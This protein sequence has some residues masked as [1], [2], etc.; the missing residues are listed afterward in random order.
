VAKQAKEPESLQEAIVYFSKP[1][2]C[3]SYMIARRWPNGV[4]CPTC[5]SEKVGFIPTRLLWECKA[6]HAKRQFSAKIGTVMEDSAIGLDKWLCAFW[7]V[8]NCK[9]GVSSYEIH[10][11]IRVTQKSAWFML[12][13]IRL[14][15]H[16][17]PG[18]KAGGEVEADETFVG[19]KVANMHKGRRV[20]IQAARSAIRDLEAGGKTGK[21][22][23][24]GILDRQTRQIRARVIPNVRREVLQ[25][26]ILKHVEHGSSVYTDDAGGYRYLPVDKFVHAVVDHEKEYV[27]GRVHTN[28]LENFWS[29]LKRS[30]KGTYVAVEPFHLDRY[31]DEQVFRFNNRATKDNPLTD[32]DR[33]CLAVSQ[34]VNKRLTYSELTGKEGK[35]P[36]L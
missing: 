1:E 25:G 28:G 24:M 8:A 16:S 30:L 29:L 34:I 27:N 31:V 20:R 15:L 18:C 5:G 36:A 2:N 23:V 19:G 6:K 22:A 3:L 33:F 17:E 12:H 9:N 14:A 32:A 11:T 10:R 26:E 35:K 13:R 4:V 7:M 21:T